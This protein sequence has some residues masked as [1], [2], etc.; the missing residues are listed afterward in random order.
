MSVFMCLSCLTQCRFLLKLAPGPLAFRHWSSLGRTPSHES[1]GGAS[2]VPC[3][4]TMRAADVTMVAAA[5]A[6]ARN[7]ATVSRAHSR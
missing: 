2:T 3:A 5:R 7:R 1:R 4:L 6:Q